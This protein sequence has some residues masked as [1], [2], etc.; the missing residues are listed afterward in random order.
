MTDV[1]ISGRNK[2]QFTGH[3]KAER[4]VYPL[5]VWKMG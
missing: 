3:D 1:E 5:H 2:V 4:R